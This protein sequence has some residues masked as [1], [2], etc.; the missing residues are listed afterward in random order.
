MKLM[1]EIVPKTLEDA[2]MQHK[3]IAVLTIEKKETIYPLIE[4]LYNAGIR[5][6]ELTLRTPIAM[7]AITIIKKDF[8]DIILGAGTVLS[9]EQLDAVHALNVDFAVAPGLNPKTIAHA[10]ALE[11]PFFPGIMTPSEIETAI[12]YGCKILKFFPAGA[13]GGLSYLK[14]ANAPYTHLGLSYIPLG[15]MNASNLSEYVA[16]PIISAVGGS[17]LAPLNLINENNWTQISKNVAEALAIITRT[18]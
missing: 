9:I 4:T 1:H 13:M 16:S 8:P 6:I 7:E 18:K 12:S 5:I 14:T 10:I 2:L 3:L 11:M 17:W 15:G